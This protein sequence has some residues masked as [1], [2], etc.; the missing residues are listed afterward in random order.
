MKASYLYDWQIG[1]KIKHLSEA[2]SKSDKSVILFDLILDCDVEL[3]NRHYAHRWVQIATQYEWCYIHG[4][5]DN[6]DNHW[7]HIICR[8]TKHTS[9]CRLECNIARAYNHV[10]CPHTEYYY[11][12]PLRFRDQNPQFILRCQP[13]MRFSEKSR[14]A[15]SHKSYIT[16]KSKDRDILS[17]IATISEK[18]QCKVPAKKKF[19]PSD[20]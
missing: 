9:S 16:G 1:Y 17:S 19:E 11:Q 14:Q 7:P 13:H 20:Q 4:D 15:S 10:F 12:K 3:T 5:P 8:H 2:S 6:P 18:S